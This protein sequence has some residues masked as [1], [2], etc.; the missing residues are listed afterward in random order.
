MFSGHY[1]RSK[2]RC[3]GGDL[4]AEIRAVLPPFESIFTE[5]P[6]EV[7]SHDWMQSNHNDWFEQT[8]LGR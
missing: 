1:P 3:A 7:Y 8:D 5:Q 4:F 2:T 6:W